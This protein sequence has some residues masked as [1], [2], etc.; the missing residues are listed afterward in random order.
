VHLGRGLVRE[1]RVR[2]SDV[3]GGACDPNAASQK[4]SLRFQIL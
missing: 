1:R 4:K 2:L 3:H